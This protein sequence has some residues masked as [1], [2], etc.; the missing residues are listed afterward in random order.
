[1]GSGRLR[2]RHAIKETSET[3][4]RARRERHSPNGVTLAPSVRIL[5]SLV[6]DGKRYLDCTNVHFGES[7]PD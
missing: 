2:Q 6:A 7:H 5:P 4:S 1:M 3:I